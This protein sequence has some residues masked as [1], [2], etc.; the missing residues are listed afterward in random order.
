MSKVT[1]LFLGIFLGATSARASCEIDVIS[2]LELIA[3]A[4]LED[5]MIDGREISNIRPMPFVEGGSHRM[6]IAEYRGRTV[7]LKEDKPRTTTSMGTP[8]GGKRRVHFLLWES[9]YLRILSEAGF[10]LKFQGVAKIN[11]ALHLVTDYLPGSRV[12]FGFFKPSFSVTS[13]QYAAYER[14]IEEVE[15]YFTRLSVK[16]IDFQF[17][18]TPDTLAVIDPVQFDIEDGAAK[19]NSDLIDY[20]KVVLRQ[21]FNSVLVRAD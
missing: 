17:L 13:K 9:I 5:F 10:G 3:Y 14:K 6:H 16:M 19:F 8:G 15:K 7:A 21:S 1:I 18:I 20:K 4:E 11:G 12:V 2:D